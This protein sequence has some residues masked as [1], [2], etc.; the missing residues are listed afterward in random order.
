MSD[1][2]FRCP[3]QNG[4][5][6]PRLRHG[7]PVLHARLLHGLRHVRPRLPERHAHSSRTSPSAGRPASRSS[8]TRSTCRALFLLGFPFLRSSPG[9]RRGEETSKHFD[10]GA[11]LQVFRRDKPQG[12]W[13]DR[14]LLAKDVLAYISADL[15]DTEET[16]EWVKAYAR[17]KLITFPPG[18]N[19]PRVAFRRDRA[20][21][22]PGRVTRSEEE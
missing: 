19:L 6:C 8:C 2:C 15:P 17:T 18:R 22:T 11:E 20:R 7:Q 3:L 12:F 14:G 1:S 21:E 4:H 13:W 9:S 10:A 16:R 5:R